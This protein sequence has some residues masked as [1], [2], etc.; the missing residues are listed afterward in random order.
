MRMKFQPLGLV[1]LLWMFSCLVSCE[2]V[3]EEES[4]KSEINLQFLPS[5]D[6]SSIANLRIHS[7]CV[8]EVYYLLEQ[9]THNRD[10]LEDSQNWKADSL[11][12]VI[13][14]ERYYQ[15]TD[16]NA[17]FHATV[18]PILDS[19]KISFVKIPQDSENLIF[20]S[21]NGKFISA[22]PLNQ[23][24]DKAGFLLFNG[25]NPPIFWLECYDYSYSYYKKFF[26]T[27]SINKK[28]PL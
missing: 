27:K 9:L 14:N 15:V 18:L 11:R 25:I 2:S 24:K 10:S 19:M 13:G 28:P 3:A 12:K 7:P 8:I 6:T 17:C 21:S 20:Y 22:L 16:A 1:C 23:F 5:T 4:A 26:D